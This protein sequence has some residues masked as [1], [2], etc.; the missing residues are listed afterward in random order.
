[1][2][3]AKK[4]KLLLEIALLQR[5]NEAHE[6]DDVKGEANH[7][8]VRCERSELG[9]GKDNMLEVVDDTLPV[10]EVIGDGEEIPVKGFA[11]GV[12]SFRRG[13][14]SLGPIRLEGEESCNFSVDET[15]T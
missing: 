9:I 7:T 11:P 10:E 4:P 3:P 1:M 8:V 6:S 2:N 14:L 12:F 15:L 13:V 5:H